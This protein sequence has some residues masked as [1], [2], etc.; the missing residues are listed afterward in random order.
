VQYLA[1]RRARRARRDRDADRVDRG[2]LARAR[3]DP[4]DARYY[5]MLATP[6]RS[7][8]SSSATRLDV[9]R[10]RRQL[11]V[12]LAVIAAFG[13]ILSPLGILALPRAS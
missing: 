4:L 10:G 7:A 11:R 6:L 5:A 8:T 13:G 9:T 2:E 3:L 12:Y 1:L